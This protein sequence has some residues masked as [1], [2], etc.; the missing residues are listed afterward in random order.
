MI[1]QKIY[2]VLE[3]QYFIIYIRIMGSYLINKINEMMDSLKL[4]HEKVYD[5]YTK[6][7]WQ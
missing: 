1:M 5:V 3:Y 7:K 2:L 6:F 4:R